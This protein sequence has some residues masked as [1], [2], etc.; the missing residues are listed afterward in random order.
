MRAMRMVRFGKTGLLVT[1]LGFGGAPIGYLGRTQSEVDALLGGLLDR[2]V[3]VLDTA[4]CYPGSEEAI[5]KAV[6]HRRSEYVLIT[7]CGHQADGLKD[8]E[9]SARLIAKTVDRSLR[10]LRTEAI[11]VLLLHSCDLETLEHGEAL[12]ALVR[13]RE[14]GKIRF[15][16]YSGDNEA[17]AW[18]AAQPD[19]AVIETSISICDQAN[20]EAVLPLAQ[21]NDLAVIAKRPLANAAWKPASEQPGVYAGYASIYTQRLSLMGITPAELGFGGTPASVWPE[22]ALRFTLAVGAVHT[23]IVGTTD[24]AHL[25]RNLAAVE[26][27]PLPASAVERI[28]RA[29]LDA[30]ARSGRRWEGET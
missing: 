28:R 5:G 2:G 15:A 25:E 24:L 21:K 26:E 10:R 18:A 30:E 17:A 29:F 12:G 14:A 8:P 16:G 7:K 19:I 4:E 9:W 20:I 13:A 3:N 1:P 27:G 23:A 22:V 11:D 6:G